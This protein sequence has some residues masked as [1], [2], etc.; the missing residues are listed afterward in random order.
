MGSSKQELPLGKIPVHLAAGLLFHHSSGVIQLNLW[1][2]QPQTLT[3][4]NPF[5]KAK[6]GRKTCV[7][8]RNLFAQPLSSIF[9]SRNSSQTPFFIFGM[10]RRFLG[11]HNWFFNELQAVHL[12]FLEFLRSFHLEVVEL[13]MQ[14][15]TPRSQYSKY[16]TVVEFK[17][18]QIL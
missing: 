10:D 4:I 7:C 8:Q 9:V 16:F 18:R 6:A 5:C 2:R 13:H 11:A 3:G 1:K 12:K 15:S 17:L 14:I